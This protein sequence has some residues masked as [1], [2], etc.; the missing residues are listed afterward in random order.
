[1]TAQPNTTALEMLEAKLMESRTS[2]ATL[3]KEFDKLGLTKEIPQE[4]TSQ[5]KP[6]PAVKRARRPA[7]P[8]AQ[9]TQPPGLA[10]PQI[11]PVQ[12]QVKS[13]Q[14]AVQRIQVQQMRP[15][16]QRQ[17]ARMAQGQIPQDQFRTVG[18]SDTETHSRRPRALTLEVRANLLSN[19]PKTLREVLEKYCL[20]EL[21]LANWLTKRPI[22]VG[23]F[24]TIERALSRINAHSIRSLPVVDKDK[25]V[26]GL[27]D[28][29]D[30]I[31]S[32]AESLKTMGDIHQI[33]EV[34][35][36]QTG[37]ARND[38]MTKSIGSLIGE[39]KG[40]VA[41]NQVS[42]MDTVRYMVE[43]EQ[44]RFMIVDRQVTGYVAKF[45]EPEQSLDGL[46]TQADVIRFLAQNA[47]LLRQ[48]PLFQITLAELGLGKRAPLIV[49]QHEIASKAFIEM[50]E[51]KSDFAAVVDDSGRL[52]ANISASDLKGLNRSNCVSLSQ[53][54][55]QF[56][57]RD[58]KRGW[59]AKPI[60]VELTDPLFF[61]VFQ[62][63]ASGVHR[64]YIVDNDGKPIGEVNHRDVLRMLL[65]I[66]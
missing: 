26:I 33:T 48:E 11:Q 39:K 55:D 14:Q 60:T 30:I 3:Q 2:L 38:F 54:L 1:M 58:W 44:E 10:Q 19:P 6:R 40:F 42:L 37:K 59:W 12:Q 28:I 52:I 62:F 24:Q 50:Y 32:I 36:Q 8:K 17:P 66:R 20:Q 4:S 21:A 35:Q 47:S 46:V 63:V 65:R 25:I 43:L 16:R 23:D 61:I 45:T 57:N 27:I 49:S 13:V 56:V 7:K 18:T 51:K 64:L 41:S 31:K 22:L 34:L 29:M 53:T 9:L 15:A 5:A